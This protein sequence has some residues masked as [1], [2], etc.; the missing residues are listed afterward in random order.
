MERPPTVHRNRS[1]IRI[2]QLA[3]QEKNDEETALLF[4]AFVDDI[5]GFLDIILWETK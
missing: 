1:I 4:A 2:V 5:D 3:L